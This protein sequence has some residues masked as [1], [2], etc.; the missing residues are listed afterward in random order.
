MLK[1][2]CMPSDSSCPN[3][4]GPFPL[5]RALFWG[6]GS[7]AIKLM[8]NIGSLRVMLSFLLLEPV[9]TKQHQR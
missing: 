7:F 9:S 5:V 6:H 4:T 2:L 3:V 8:L 1:L